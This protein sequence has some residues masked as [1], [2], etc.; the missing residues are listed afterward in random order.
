MKKRKT[1]SCISFSWFI[2]SFSSNIA[3]TIVPLS[4]APHWLLFSFFSVILS[5]I[6]VVHRG[7]DFRCIWC[8]VCF[9][10]AVVVH[11]GPKVCLLWVYH[12][13]EN[14]FSW[15]IN[16][17]V[18]LMNDLREWLWVIE[19]ACFV[20]FWWLGY[21]VSEG[22]VV[23]L[24]EF[25]C[26]L[27][28]NAQWCVLFSW[29]QEGFRAWWVWWFFFVSEMVGFGVGD[30][31]FFF[32][33]ECVMVCIVSLISKGWEQWFSDWWVLLFCFGVMVFLVLK[34]VG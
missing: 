33:C 20:V 1:F 23:F 2:F 18:L 25:Y 15:F 6:V 8:G 28:L 21:M 30:S 26:G 24:R 13:K 9:G 34:W 16:Y 12:G 5:A 29:S 31:F 22:W 14:V 4:S 10:G 32:G 11:F 27:V 19:F 3:L 17:L 7:E